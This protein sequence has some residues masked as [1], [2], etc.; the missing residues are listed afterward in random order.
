MFEG[1]VSE[2]GDVLEKV[3]QRN[4]GCI[5]VQD[6]WGPDQSIQWVA[7]QYKAGCLKLYDL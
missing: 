1:N 5:Q 6:G 7:T 4:P 3:V 2:S